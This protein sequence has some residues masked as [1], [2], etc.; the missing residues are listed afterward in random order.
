MNPLKNVSGDE[1]NNDRADLRAKLREILGKD[2]VPRNS[3]EL[4][5]FRLL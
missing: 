2:R 4:F 5:A 1:K 3:A